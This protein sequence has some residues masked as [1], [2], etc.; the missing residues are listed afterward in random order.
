MITEAFQHCRGI[1]PVRLAQLRA[2]GVCDWQTAIDHQDRVPAAIRQAVLLEC[3]EAIGALDRD[4]IAFFV[5][6]FSPQDRW[7][8]LAHFLD[9]T[10]FFDIETT[11]LEFDDE[12]TVI[13]CWHRGR[14]HCFCEHEDLDGFLDLLEDVELLASFN[15]SCFDV[16]R[17]IDTFHVPELPCPH[18]DLRWICYYHGLFGGLKEITT[19]IGV[20]RPADLEDV[21]G[22]QAAGLWWAWKR[23]GDQTAKETLV[24]YCAADVLLL[25]TLAHHLAGTRVSDDGELWA[26]LP[27]QA[28]RR[29]DDRGSEHHVH[30]FGGTGRTRLRDRI[31]RA[32]LAKR[33]VEVHKKSD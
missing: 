27:K 10:S 31:S 11:G 22:A 13:V 7:R 29:V 23:H 19:Q 17:V 33:V 8:I 18:L 1:G 26:A 3:R 5:N 28:H 21:D 32:S 20:S 24:R 14:L 6:R 9:R 15:G 2:A 25:V 16:P 4:D 30:Q 12:V